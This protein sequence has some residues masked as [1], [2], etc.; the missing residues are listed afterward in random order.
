MMDNKV[1]MALKILN[2]KPQHQ[3]PVRNKR[4]KS[5]NEDSRYRAGSQGILKRNNS[6][7]AHM[8]IKNEFKNMKQQAHLIR[9]R[10]D[11]INTFQISKYNDNLNQESEHANNKKSKM[12]ALQMQCNF[13]SI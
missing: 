9:N 3:S 7:K 2:R 10:V 4:E 1:K 13:Q 8:V 12:N 5:E 11:C 6:V